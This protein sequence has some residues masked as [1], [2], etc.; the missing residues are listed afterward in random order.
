MAYIDVVPLEIAK[1]YLGIDDTS[2][3]AEITRMI[4]SACIYVEKYTNIIL[5]STDKT[6]YREGRDIMVYDYPINTV[7]ENEQKR[8]NYSIFN[9]DVVELNV[10]YELA[11]DVPTDIV[12]AVLQI[13]SSWFYA[14][15]EKTSMGIPKGAKMI[16]DLNK[17]FIL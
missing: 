6:Y 11:T 12:D 2:R 8:A 13:V 9:T 14:S 17:R 15:E 3:D 5:V 10:G 7:D 1:D 4:N 16:L